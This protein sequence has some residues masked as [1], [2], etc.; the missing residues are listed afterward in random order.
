MKLL[1]APY[2]AG[3]WQASLSY[4]IFSPVP[5]L[6]LRQRGP[7]LGFAYSFASEDITLVSCDLHKERSALKTLFWLFFVGVALLSAGFFGVLPAVVFFC[8]AIWASHNKHGSA[9]VHT[10]QG[11][12]QMR[13]TNDEYKALRD[14]AGQG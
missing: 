4:G 3:N 12:F 1:K 13:L 11:R 6:K 9:S 14:Y 5:K 7:G 10:P 2:G 8:L